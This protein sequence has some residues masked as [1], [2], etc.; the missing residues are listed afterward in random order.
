MKLILKL[1]KIIRFLTYIPF[2]ILI[3]IGDFYSSFLK[4]IDR[5]NH[6]SFWQ[7]TMQKSIDKNISRNI[8]ISNYPKKIIKFYCPSK[9]ASF[10]AK[11]FFS[12]EPETLNWMDTHGSNNKCLYG[13]PDTEVEVDF[14]TNSMTFGGKNYKNIGTTPTSFSVRDNSDFVVLNR[15]NLKLTFDYQRSREIYQCNESEI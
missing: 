13:D 5:R 14:E 3:L 9:I 1:V 11:T 15:G 2:K 10:R 7:E 12:K 6:D 8:Q 4:I